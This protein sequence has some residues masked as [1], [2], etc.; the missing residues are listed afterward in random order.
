MNKDIKQIVIIDDSPEDQEIVKRYLKSNDCCVQESY[1]F[2]DWESAREHLLKHK[3]DIILLDH[4]LGSRTS[5]D[6]IP[7]I[8]VLNYK[9][10]LIVLTGQKDEKI[11]ADIIKKGADDYLN[12]NNLNPELLRVSINAA[13]NNWKNKNQQEYLLKQLQ[14]IQRMDT[15]GTFAGGIAHDF[16]NML[17][18]IM[19]FVEIGILKTQGR[20]VEKD[21]RMA[22]ESCQTMSHMVGRLLSFSRSHVEQREYIEINDFIAQFKTFSTHL[23]PKNIEI[24][25]RLMPG[26][27]YIKSDIMDINQIFLN[28]I[29]N[30]SDAMPSGG[31]IV[32]ESRL[33]SEPEV[34][35]PDSLGKNII[36]TVADTGS[37]IPSEV[38]PRIFDPY[39]TTKD[40][41]SNKGTGLGLSIVWNIVQDISASIKVDSEPGIGTVF[42]LEI[43]LVNEQHP[44]MKHENTFLVDEQIS[45]F[46][47][48]IIVADDEEKV[49]L[50]MANILSSL[51][52]S[53]DT[54]S[55]GKELIALFQ[56]GHADVI[57]VFVDLSMPEIGGVECIKELKKIKPDISIIVI[58][59]HSLWEIKDDLMKMG[60]K[61]LIQKPFTLTRLT[62]AIRQSF[63]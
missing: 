1:S 43:P 61:A 63:Y 47:E 60:V 33:N 3:V 20:E 18:S 46:Q 35:V 42:T 30:A 27:M 6:I 15:I 39:F 8:R 50:Y 53:V 12:K 24:E 32:I 36:I 52:Y 57:G 25:L 55:S 7:E 16:N 23:I 62:T 58:S 4:N 45:N 21:L 2:N 34:I 59:G 31:K 5:L 11:A 22:Y 10:P 26:K 13:L 41:D 51:G 14:H 49:R 37:G 38:L 19:G 44:E 28:L 17:T 40:M 54:V 48:K 56:K 29:K 9:G